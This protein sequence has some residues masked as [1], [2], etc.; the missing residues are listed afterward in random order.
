VLNSLLEVRNLRKYFLLKTGLPRFVKTLKRPLKS[1]TKEQKIEGDSECVH[2]VDGISFEIS[3]GET[4]GLVGESGCGKTTAARCIL[5]LI[6]PTSG[7]VL[8]RGIDL[9]ELQKN[10]LRMMRRHMQ[11]VFQDPTGSLN[12]RL[13][14][15]TLLSEPMTNFQIVQNS[16]ETHKRV[17]ELLK[18]VGLD[19]EHIDKYPHELSGGMKQRV[20]I[21]R[22]LASNPDLVIL[23]EPTSALDASVGAKILNLLID[24]QRELGTTYLFIAHDLAVVRYICNRVAVMYLGKIFEMAGVEDIFSNPLHPYTEA[25][26]S[27]VP[28]PDPTIRRQRKTLRGEPPSP[29]DLPA[30]CRFQGRC[31]RAKDICSQAEPQL[32][33]VETNHFVS[34]YLWQ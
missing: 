9:T 20:G 34:C 4:F 11:L 14:V 18:K 1:G 19:E 30:G 26:L 29:I 27:S 12:P 31:P 33:E 5:R 17:V 21:A 32:K 2:A 15:R 22:A 3:T 24:L 25:L 7:K 13:K 8:F 16:K 10:E 28:V 23:D 6:E